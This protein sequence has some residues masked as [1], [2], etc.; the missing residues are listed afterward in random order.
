MK[1][2]QSLIAVLVAALIA[3]QVLPGI[4]ITVGIQKEENYGNQPNG[5]Y[6]LM[7]P[8][9]EVRHT[10][11]TNYDPAPKMYVSLKAASP[12]GSYNLISHLSY[13]PVERDQ[14]SCGNCWVWAGTG[15]LEVALDVNEGIFDRLSVQ[16]FNSKYNDGTGPDWAGNGGWLSDFAEFYANEGYAIPWSNTNA[17]YADGHQTGED[18]TSVPWYTI[19]TEPN[20]TMTQCTLESIVTHGVGQDAAINNIKN[21]INQGRAVWFGYFLANEADWNQFFNFWDYQSENAIWNPDYSCGD[22]WDSGGGGHAVL[23]VGY[24]DEDPN[25]AY[26]IMVNSWGTAYGGRP[27]CI[28]R[29]DMNMDYDCYFFDPYPLQYYSFYWQTLNVTYATGYAE[30]S[31]T[32]ASIGSKLHESPNSAYF[33]F[34]DPT[35]M[36]SPISAYD[37]ASGGIIYGLFENAQNQVFDSNSDNV[38]Q[39][40]PEKGKVTTHEKTVLFF[41]GPVIHWCVQYYES[42]GFAPVKFHFNIT[43]NTCNFVTQSENPLAALSATN[44]FDHEDM[45]VIEVFLDG[46]NNTVFMFYGFGWKGTW[47]AGIYFHDFLND[48]ITTLTNSHYIYH[49]SDVSMDGVPQPNEIHQEYP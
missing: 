24:N 12:R 39:V 31:P 36:A 20:Y 44:D 8:S 15:V 29:L 16:Y 2:G 13:D 7:R 30:L 9:L 4:N 25:N 42:A 18:G 47:A 33:I 41:G 40:G 21:V 22:I 34:A 19:S 3:V 11:L 5:Y 10:L 26:W 23:C 1:T 48:R 37:V 6:P 43:A 46:N 32:M 14:G 28:F 27:N 49:W 17:Y 38:V 45:F 35:R